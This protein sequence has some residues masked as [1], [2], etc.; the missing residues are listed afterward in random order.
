M[1]KLKIKNIILI[2]L[3][4]VFIFSISRIILLCLDLNKNNRN[5][6]KLIDQ[7]VN[8]EIDEETKEEVIKIDFDNLTSINSDT[9]GWIKYNQ[10]KIN[11]PI[12]QANDNSYYLKKAFDKSYNQVGSIFMDYRN[13]SFDD[14]NVVLF[15]HAMIDG[16][17]FGTLKD[18]FQ[19]N[20]FDN[21][22]NNYIQIINKDNVILTYQIFS[23]YI[24]EK[25]EY[26]ITTSFNNDND[27]NGFVNTIKNRSYKNFDVNV[28][29]NDYILTLSTCSG[30]G[31][32]SERKVIHA[33]RI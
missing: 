33:K 18:L 13:N 15:G 11:Y 9:V 17:M 24:I 22:E 26:Y 7:V 3:V 2:L 8:I 4:I 10:D 19:N 1:K 6:K 14:K 29:I 25:E 23:Y 21:V 16:S 30:M 27:F 31:G 32:S 12:V 20:F 28:S 5:S